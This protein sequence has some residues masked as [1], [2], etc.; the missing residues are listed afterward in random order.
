M[1]RNLLLL[2]ACLSVSASLLAADIRINNPKVGNY[3]LDY[4]LRWAQACGKP[5]ADAYCRKRGHR[6]ALRFGV[7]RDRPPTR[8]IDGGQVCDAPE[9]DRISWVVCLADDVYKNPKVDG[10]PL[11][12]CRDWARNCGKPAA[13]AFCQS[14]GHRVSVDFSVRRDSP[15]TRVISEGRICKGPQC[16]RIVSVTCLAKDV[17]R[18]PPRQ[19][20]G[21]KPRGGGGKKDAAGDPG[22]YED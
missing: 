9:C 20:A 11:D 13:D 1:K 4:C 16:D 18:R 5:A 21:Q 12:Y 2:V 19:D 14:R 22:V 8:V 17:K 10:Y 15:P 7:A 6:T 3:A